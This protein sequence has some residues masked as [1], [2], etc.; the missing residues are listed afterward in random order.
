MIKNSS[1][2]NEERNYPESPEVETEFEDDREE[3][4]EEEGQEPPE[5]EEELGEARRAEG[6]G[7]GARGMEIVGIFRGHPFRG[8]PHY[9]LIYHYLALSSPVHE[10][11]PTPPG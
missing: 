3:D 7:E 5:V 11:A 4:E 1:L 9:E 8:P 10:Q 2:K 6:A